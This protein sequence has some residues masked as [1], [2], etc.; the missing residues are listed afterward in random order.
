MIV[1]LSQ[2]DM[3]YIYKIKLERDFVTKNMSPKTKYGTDHS[4]KFWA[5]S[6]QQFDL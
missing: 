1:N 4:C 3:V 6:S 5:K 2:E